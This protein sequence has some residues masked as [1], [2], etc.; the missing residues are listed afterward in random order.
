MT[1]GEYAVHYSSFEDAPAGSAPSCTVFG[2]LAEA[3]A[4]AREQV[5]RRPEL[6]CRIYDHQGF[7]GAPVRE[8]SGSDYKGESFISARFRRWAGSLLFFGGVLLIALD[9]THDFLLTWP[10]TIGARMV[11]PGLILLVT[12]TVVVVLA[13]RKRQDRGER[14]VV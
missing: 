6:R 1:A 2:S 3:E 11:I 4:Y 8:F 13:R 12:E 10:A 9:W 14:K 7:V 5:A